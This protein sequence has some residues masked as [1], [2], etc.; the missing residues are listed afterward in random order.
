MKV[1][2]Y[3]L[4]RDRLPY[5]QHCLSS[6]YENA[7]YPFKHFILDN[8]SQ[9]GTPEWLRVNIPPE[10]TVIYSQENL[11]IARAA[12]QLRPQ[13][14][15]S[16]PDLIIK[17]DNDCEVLTPNILARIVAFYE[18]V[19]AEGA[20]LPVT[21]PLVHG[22]RTRVGRI[23]YAKVGLFTLEY[24]QIVG[25]IFHVV[26]VGVYSQYAYDETLPKAFGNDGHFCKWLRERGVPIGYISE[27]DVAHYE[28]TDGQELRFPVYFKRKR[29]EEKV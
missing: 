2:V 27:L 28:T 19:K 3:T 20:V 18:A 5:T 22:L 13:V 16:N 4:T 10:H 26:P 7:G 17:L 29:I 12:N 8:G 11:G 21:S 24:T 23:G 6:F 9:D 14:L 15:S 25:G 1:A